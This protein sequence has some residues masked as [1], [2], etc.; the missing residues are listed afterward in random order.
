MSLADSLATC[1]MIDC[2]LSLVNDDETLNLHSPTGTEDRF[3][4]DYV[5]KL[6][7]LAT[8]A[9][10]ADAPSYETCCRDGGEES[11]RRDPRRSAART[12]RHSPSGSGHRRRPVDGRLRAAPERQRGSVPRAPERGRGPRGGRRPDAP[13]SR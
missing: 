9:K 1:T 12:D 2:P 3:R 8:V 4:H 11:A 5:A 10:L 7:I 13:G 6:V